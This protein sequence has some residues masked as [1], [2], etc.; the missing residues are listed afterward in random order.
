MLTDG[1]TDR[2]TNRQ[3]DGQGEINVYNYVVQGYNKQGSY[4]Q[5]RL[6]RMNPEICSL[7]LTP[8]PPRPVSPL[9]QTKTYF[10]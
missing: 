6:L 1:Q 5:A 7:I 10:R 4:Q 9:C 8:N 2:E 3:T